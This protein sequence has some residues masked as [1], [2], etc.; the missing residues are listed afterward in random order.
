M[1]G[2]KQY[3]LTVICKPHATHPI[4]HKEDMWLKGYFDENHDLKNPDPGEKVIKSN[5]AKPKEQIRVPAEKTSLQKLI[6]QGSQ[7]FHFLLEKEEYEANKYFCYLWVEPYGAAALLCKDAHQDTAVGRLALE[8]EHEH[9]KGA[10]K[11]TPPNSQPGDEQIIFIIEKVNSVAQYMADEINTNLHSKSAQKMHHFNKMAKHHA[12]ASDKGWTDAWI[13]RQVSDNYKDK[14]KNEF[15]RQV[16]AAPH[17][18]HSMR[19]QLSQNFQDMWF[20]DGGDW[21]H[22]PRIYPIWGTNNRLGNSAEYYYYDIWSNIHFAYIGRKVGFSYSELNSGAGIAQLLDKLSLSGDPPRD[23]AAVKEGYNLGMK[24]KTA[25]SFKDLVE[26]LN[27]HPEWV[28]DT[29]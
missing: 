11:V 20:G 26:I 2:T 14:A 28:Y 24:R 22:K 23:A 5:K 19:Q 6:P 16:H 17:P 3:W 1:S 7:K 27:R 21:D 8:G 29:E 4:S 9:H 18:E 25:V 13:A 12:P 15:G 10:L